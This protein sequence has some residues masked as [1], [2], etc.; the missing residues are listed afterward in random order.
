MIARYTDRLSGFSNESV[1]YLQGATPGEVLD[2]RDGSL[3]LLL[4]TPPLYVSFESGIAV[5]RL[6]NGGAAV[7]RRGRE[8]SSE[9]ATS[10]TTIA[11]A[12]CTRIDFT[13]VD[14]ANKVD[15]PALAAAIGERRILVST[16]RERDID[17]FAISGVSIDPATRRVTVR[18]RVGD[19]RSRSVAPSAAAQVIEIS[20][21]LRGRWLVGLEPDPATP[22]PFGFWTTFAIDLG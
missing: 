10:F 16:G 14:V 17:T 9:H 15:C 21:S 12:S 8:Q 3:G 2:P 20:E 11:E 22:R 5:V 4:A 6:G 7:L 1:T 18:I 19:S 13:R